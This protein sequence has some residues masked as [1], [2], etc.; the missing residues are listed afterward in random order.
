MK[1]IMMVLKT[2]PVGAR[3]HD[4]RKGELCTTSKETPTLVTIVT[5]VLHDCTASVFG[6][7]EGCTNSPHQLGDC[8][9][10]YSLNLMPEWF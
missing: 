6:N 4:V 1:V 5:G 8:L 10:H 9:S 7:W 3:L 2:V